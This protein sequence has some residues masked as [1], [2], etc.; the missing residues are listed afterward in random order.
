M[1]KIIFN[2]E[3]IRID[4][5]LT[6]QTNKSR[7][8]IQNLIDEEFIKVNGKKIK[9]SYILQ[10][11]DVIIINEKEVVE[12]KIEKKNIPLD[13]VYED[14]DLIVVNKPSGMVVHPANG[15]YDDTLV[16]ALMYHCKDLSTING[17]I[18]PGIVHRIDKDTSGLLVACKNDFSHNF[19]AK[20]LKEK[21]TLRKYIAIVYGNFD[22]MYGKVDAPIARDKLNRKKMAVDVDGKNSVTTFKVLKNY[23]GYSLLELVLETGRTH[24][25]RVH[26]A[27]INHPVLGDPMYGP[28]KK[29]TEFGQ[30]LHAKELGFV[31]PRTN[32]FMKFDSNLP[33]EFVDMIDKLE[34]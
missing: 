26:M 10:I 31:H 13:V 4:K 3:P 22:H 29:V 28:K 30:Y 18:R 15:H 32:K 8:E 6:K 5:Y 24:Q 1:N 34:K 16:N 33:Q 12:A 25:I 7:T 20:Q 11:N 27:Y 9:P 21:T 19:I 23:N 2:D 14:S 17:E